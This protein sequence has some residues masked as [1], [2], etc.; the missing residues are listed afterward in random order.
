MPTI[1]NEKKNAE[2]DRPVGA[3]TRST[4]VLG[5]CPRDTVLYSGKRERTNMRVDK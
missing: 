1:S 3:C 4:A 2:A 5:S